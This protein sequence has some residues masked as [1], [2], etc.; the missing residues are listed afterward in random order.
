MAT[1]H[2]GGL[3]LR[4]LDP[5]LHH[6]CEQGIAPNTNKTYQSALR[7]FAHFCSLYC[8]LTLFP[9][10]ESLL[11]YFATHLACQQLSPQTVKVYMAA[12]R[13][14]QITMGLPE[15]REYSSMPRL[16]LV[17]STH[18]SKQATK[19]RLPITPAIL[20]KLK[21]HWTPRKS[22]PDII[23]LWAAAVLCFFGFFR[24]REITIPT[25]SGFDHSKYLAWGDV[26]TDDA[27]QLK[28]SKTD[29]LGKGID[30]YI[31][32]TDDPLCPV[33]A[34]MAYMAIRGP[35]PGAFFK[36]SNGHPLTKSAF[37][38]K[39]RAGLQAIGLP[40]SDFAGHSFRIGAATTAANAGIEDSV[41]RT[42]GRWSSSAFLTY[43]RTPRDQL[44]RFSKTLASS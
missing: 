38:S 40:E 16:R 32:K 33:T 20:I 34:T 7:R 39:I 28:R 35:T 31:G 17:Q 3:D 30:I 42:L 26:A 43:I 4:T 19:I 24:A 22:D 15:P 25:V 9:V 44:A 37:T 11:C 21:K 5:A 8:I 1:G 2:T 14:M 13:H 6:F 27:V 23:M 36:L 10:S 12:I 29:Q 41:I 18:A